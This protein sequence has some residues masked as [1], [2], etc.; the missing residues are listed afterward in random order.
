MTLATA[1]LADRLARAMDGIRS[2]GAAAL[3]VGLGADLRYLTGYTGHALERLTMLVVPY[4]G[5]PTMVAPRLEA[6]AAAALP[7]C[8]GGLVEVVAWDETDDP[9]A[10][11]AGRTS[12]SGR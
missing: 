8:T 7:V 11:V 10:I 9:Y 3:L 1:T 4:R 5:R 12:A 6:M 2:N